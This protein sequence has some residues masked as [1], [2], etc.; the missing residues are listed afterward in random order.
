MQISVNNYNYFSLFFFCSRRNTLYVRRLDKQQTKKWH[1]L[2]LKTSFFN[3]KGFYVDQFCQLLSILLWSRSIIGSD[4]GRRER[5][6]KHDR[7]RR[8]SLEREIH[9]TKKLRNASSGQ[10]FNI[11]ECFIVFPKECIPTICHFGLC[12]L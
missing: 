9:D 12:L 2:Y 10:H 1:F 11:K 8:G 7:G 6:R 3:Y 4:P 5:R